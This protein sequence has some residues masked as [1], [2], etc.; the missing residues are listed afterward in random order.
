MKQEIDD[1]SVC[2]LRLKHLCK[3]APLWPSIISARM[4]K[5]GGEG[6]GGRGRGGLKNGF[7]S[8]DK[9]VTI[10]R[11]RGENKSK[12]FCILLKLCRVKLNFVCVL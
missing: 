12:V 5:G 6:E 3:P 7:Y 9:I 4:G 11:S 1:L 10:E 2:C 8:Q